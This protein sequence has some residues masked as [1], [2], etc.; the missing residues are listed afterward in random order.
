MG[1]IEI[2]D[3]RTHAR[4]LDTRRFKDLCRRQ[5]LLALD[6]WIWLPIAYLSIREEPEFCRQLV[7]SFIG[8]ILSFDA[9]AG[10]NCLE[11]ETVRYGRRLLR[12][13]TAGE[14]AAHLRVTEQ[15]ARSILRRLVDSHHLVVESGKIRYRTYQ[16][17]VVGGLRQT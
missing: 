16:L 7:L 9:D 13:F 12:P 10:L 11:A 17:H 5:S 15:Y 1:N 2:Q 4:D 14:L 3:Y 8:K 6:G